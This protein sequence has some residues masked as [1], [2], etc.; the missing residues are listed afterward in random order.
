MPSKKLPQGTKSTHPQPD[1]T[2]DNM[3]MVDQKAGLRLEKRRYFT[4]NGD[5][6][7]SSELLVSQKELKKEGKALSSAAKA[8]ERSQIMS[9]GSI[10]FR[11][12]SAFYTF[13]REI[14]LNTGG[15]GCCFFRITRLR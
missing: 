10:T 11:T 6:L 7:R 12:K 14:I 2:T 3:M 15:V 13:S 4:N 9:H 1:A 5:H 8:S